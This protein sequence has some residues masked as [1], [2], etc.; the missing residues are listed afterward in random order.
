M[1]VGAHG[2]GAENGDA[3]GGHVKLGGFERLLFGDA[4]RLKGLCVRRGAGVV[5]KRGEAHVG[6]LFAQQHKH[7]DKEHRK[8][9]HGQ[10]AVAPAPADILHHARED[11]RHDGGRHARARVGKPHGKALFVHKPVADQRGD[12]HGQDGGRQEAVKDGQSVK[13]PQLCGKGI[14]QNARAHH[15]NGDARKGQHGVFLIEVS[16]DHLHEHAD[17]RGNGGI[18]REGAARKAEVFTDG[19]D[20]NAVA[21]D[22]Q[23]DAGAHHESAAENHNPAVKE[24]GTP[25]CRGGELFLHGVQPFFFYFCSQKKVYHGGKRQHKR[26]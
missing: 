17:E 7:R 8:A 6:G 20:E 26:V 10:Q 23:A 14:A 15:K 21:V 12:G 25:R 9:G 5:V 18:E 1:G 13:V 24:L 4:H 22:K 2:G 11:G 3:K 19:L 16:V